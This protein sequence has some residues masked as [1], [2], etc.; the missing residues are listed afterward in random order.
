MAEN[1]ITG[2][3]PDMYE[4]LDIVSRE[5]V[6]MIPAVT[7][8]ASAERA[9]K[10][11]EIKVSKEPTGNVSD[12]VP[13][14]TI[15]EPTG[16]TTGSTSVIITKERA[17]EFGFI[18]NQQMALNAGVGYANSRAGKIAQAIRALTN[19]VETDLCALQSTFSRAYGTAGTTPFATAGDY[20]DASFAKKILVDNGAPEFDTHLV[21]NTTAGATLS[22]K[23]SAANIA[24]TDSMQRQ[25][26]LL[27]LQGLDLRQ[28]AQTVTQT[29]G[30]MASA[31]TNNAGYAIGATV[32][33]LA[34]AGTGVVAAGDIVTFAGDANKYVVGSVVFAG[35]NPAAGDTITLNGTGLRVAITTSATA[36]TVI[37]TS[38]RNM[39]FHRSAIV[40]AARTPAMPE[41]GD[42]AEDGII[43]TDPR[44]GLSLEFLMYKG[45]RKVRYEVGLA[46]GVKNIKEEHTGLLLG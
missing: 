1:T 43:I 38:A 14:M 16:Q 26:I 5:V 31:T 24:G 27:P 11:S 36:I 23:Q 46:W 41:E 32:I 17:A 20:T 22:G 18:G 25:G 37:A 12:I 6:G 21:M 44:S 10:D 8:N 28:S 39:C 35:A 42:Q 34:T 45:R 30:A 3:I 29:A 9:A 2:L 19:E 15:A 13:A 33:T 7:M 40:L 4:A